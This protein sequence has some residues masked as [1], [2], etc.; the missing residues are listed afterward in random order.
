MT[1]RLR[2]R[3]GQTVEYRSAARKSSK[4]DHRGRVKAL[5][6]ALQEKGWRSLGYR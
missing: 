1:A 3:G 2:G 6:L 4:A 5:R